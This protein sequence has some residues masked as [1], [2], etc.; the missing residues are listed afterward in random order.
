M[1]EL[2]DSDIRLLRALEAPLPLVERPFAD[3]ARRAGL[4]EDEAIERAR[5]FVE[6]G[7]IRRFGARVNHRSVG[8][9]ANGMSVWNVPDDRVD[10]TAAVMTARNE[11]SHCYV[12]QKF[13]GWPYNMYAMIHGMSEDDVRRVARDVAAQAGLNDYDILFSTREFKKTAPVYFG[14]KETT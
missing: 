5:Q 3:V 10:A 8:Y 11:I 4:A 14:D 7:I 9:T 12:R 2:S 1:I 6:Q 13:S